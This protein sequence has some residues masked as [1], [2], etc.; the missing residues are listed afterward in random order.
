MKIQS[1]T[2]LTKTDL[3][4]HFLLQKTVL[5]QRIEGTEGAWKEHWQREHQALMK[6][7]WV[8]GGEA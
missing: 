2:D 4:Q 6:C 7:L 8:L 3:Y 1:R 5:E